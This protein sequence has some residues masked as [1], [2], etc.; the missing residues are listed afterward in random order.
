MKT[1]SSSGSALTWE[2]LLK[3]YSLKL[4]FPEE[5][6]KY[7]MCHTILTTV[8]LPKLFTERKSETI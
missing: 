7:I 5:I 1:G 3:S 2:L 4:Y 6:L 8:I